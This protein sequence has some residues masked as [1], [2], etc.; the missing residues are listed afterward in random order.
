[1]AKK[2]GLEKEIVKF[3]EQR[4][5]QKEAEQISADEIKNILQNEKQL[6][7]SNEDFSLALLALLSKGEIQ[8][9]F[10]TFA[11]D[12]FYE[13][14]FKDGVFFIKLRKPEDYE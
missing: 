1:M 7:F 2:L 3:L 14:E 10:D 6:E 11:P 4:E 8:G 5:A 13:E 9:E 12:P